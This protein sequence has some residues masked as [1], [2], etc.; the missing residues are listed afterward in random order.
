MN[1]IAPVFTID[2]ET[3]MSTQFHRRKPRSWRSVV[4]VIYA[5]NQRITHYGRFT[6]PTAWRKVASY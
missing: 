5:S 3:R 6:N 2:H 1:A 4:T